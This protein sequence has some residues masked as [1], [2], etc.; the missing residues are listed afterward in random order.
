MKHV[1]CICCAR[2]IHI[3]KYVVSNFCLPRTINSKYWRGNDYGYSRKKMYVLYIRV[4]RIKIWIQSFGWAY[5]NKSPCK[6][7]GQAEARQMFEFYKHFT[8]VFFLLIFILVC[9]CCNQQS[10]NQQKGRTGKKLEEIEWEWKKK[11]NK[12]FIEGVEW[13]TVEKMHYQHLYR[14]L[15][16]WFSTWILYISLQRIRLK[17]RK[18]WEVDRILSEANDNSFPLKYFLVKVRP[19][20][21]KEM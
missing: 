10:Q 14:T 12:L 1:A 6:T 19:S 8:D 9:P 11:F 20:I 2:I 15:W 21:A 7:Y 17:E 4:Q 13:K 18:R 5:N 3:Y 16:L